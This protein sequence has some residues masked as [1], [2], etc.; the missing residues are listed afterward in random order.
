MEQSIGN[1]NKET[2]EV[3]IQNTS[4]MKPGELKQHQMEDVLLLRELAMSMERIKEDVEIM[5]TIL[6]NG[7]STLL[8][9]VL[10]EISTGKKH[11]EMPVQIGLEKTLI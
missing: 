3:L 8:K 11:M 7:E 6:M 4:M 1:L 2:Q 9:L 5:E 10:Q